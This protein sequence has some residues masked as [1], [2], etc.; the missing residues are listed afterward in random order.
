M[1]HDRWKGVLPKKGV[2]ARIL[3]GGGDGERTRRAKTL[4]YIA[5]CD[6]NYKVKPFAGG[7]ARN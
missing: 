1:P 4:Y 6:F 2:R 7:T 3:Y 5:V